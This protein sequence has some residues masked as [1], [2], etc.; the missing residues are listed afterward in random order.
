M[1]RGAMSAQT[2]WS[3]HTSVEAGERIRHFRPAV[4]HAHNTLPLPWLSLYFAGS[5][6]LSGERREL[7]GG[8]PNRGVALMI[9]EPVS[10]NEGEQLRVA[11]PIQVPRPRRCLSPLHRGEPVELATL[12]WVHRYNTGRLHRY[13]G[14]MPPAEFD[15][16][17][18]AAPAT[19]G[20]PGNQQNEPPSNPGEIHALDRMVPGIHRDKA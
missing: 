7:S 11:R 6:R 1:G 3:R 12:K 4:V 9:R 15:Q 10:G 2:S 20:P 5:T 16:A 18:Y 14:D 8:L 17:H 19:G 13:R